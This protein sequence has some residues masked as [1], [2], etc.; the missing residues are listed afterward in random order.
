MPQ[1]WIRTANSACR[2]GALMFGSSVVLWP[3][4]G[5]PAVSLPRV[6]VVVRRVEVR[7]V[8]DV[9]QL[10]D[11]LGA[12]GCAMR[13]IF[14]SRRST[15]AKPGQ[16]TVVTSVSPRAAAERV[17]RVEIQVAAAAAAA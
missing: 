8:E 11:E 12:G 4:S 9:E 5:R 3:N 13:K 17:D 14:D 1:N 2:D 7:A 10:R 16:S 15:L 6:E